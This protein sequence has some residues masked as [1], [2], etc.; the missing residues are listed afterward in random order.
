M[1]YTFSAC[2]WMTI[3]RI[4][5]IKDNIGALHENDMSFFT[6][7]CALFFF[8][9]RF[10]VWR[11]PKTFGQK[12]ACQ[13]RKPF[14]LRDDPLIRVILAK[15]RKS[16]SFFGKSNNNSKLFHW[17]QWFQK[18]MFFPKKKAAFHTN[19]HRWVQSLACISCWSICTTRWQMDDHWL[20]SGWKLNE[21]ETFKKIMEV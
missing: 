5:E 2:L 17:F 19:T 3:W 1:C 13:V 6:E 21:V 20:F 11:P 9:P 4:H 12:R 16:W 15:V 7:F 18:H 14:D 10:L 8:S